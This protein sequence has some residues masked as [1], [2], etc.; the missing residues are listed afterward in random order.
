MPK[1]RPSLCVIGGGFTGVAA[2]IGCLE[3][4]KEPF[5]L[6]VIEPDASLGRGVAFGDHPLHL[7]NVRARDLSIHAGRPGDFLTRA[8]PRRKH[9]SC[10]I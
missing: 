3:R 1:R 9:S 2:A 8:L 5:R 4:V 7:L 6:H 10:T